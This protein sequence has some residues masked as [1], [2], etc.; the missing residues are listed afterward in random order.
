MNPYLSIVM[1]VGG[2]VT[3]DLL[4]R[5]NVSATETTKLAKQVG[6]EMEL[7]IVEWNMEPMDHDNVMPFTKIPIRIIHAGHVHATYQNPHSLKYFEMPAKNIGIR[8]AHGEFV[9]STNPDDLFT[10]ELFEFFAS[11]SLRHG[12][13]YRANRH[14]TKD[15]KVYRVCHATGCHPPGANRAQIEVSQPGAAPYSPS[16]LHFN[17]SGD[18]LLMAKDD[19]FNI[20]GNPERDYNHT[21]DGEAVWLAHTHGLQQVVLPHPVYH[22][23]HQRS[24][25]I[26]PEGNFVGPTDWDD[27]QPYAVENPDTWG[28]RDVTFEESVL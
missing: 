3:E 14:D 27:S 8:R 26:G 21:L 5:L 12:F 22:P 6:L 16:M 25:N 2:N 13:F 23:D 11:N 10:R 20:H 15:G 24:L 28:F 9:L 4:D 7:V 19:W 17:A 1:G 18:F